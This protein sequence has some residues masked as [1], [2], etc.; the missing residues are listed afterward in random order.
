MAAVL[1]PAGGWSEG[2]THRSGGRGAKRARRLGGSLSVMV[3]ME[4]EVSDLCVKESSCR[5]TR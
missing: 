3:M 5:E 4:L 2:G 1:R